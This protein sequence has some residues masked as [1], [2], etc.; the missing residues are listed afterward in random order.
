MAYTDDQLQTIFNR[1]G[2]YCFYC[3]ARLAWGN[4]RLLGAVGAW[5]ADQRGVCG[6]SDHVP[7]CI[8]CHRIEGTE[9]GRHFHRKPALG[10]NAWADRAVPVLSH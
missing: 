7:S 2:G 6:G 5:K 3:G 4:Y 9:K 10:R 8:T 1:T